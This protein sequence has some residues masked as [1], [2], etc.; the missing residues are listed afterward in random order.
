MTDTRPIWLAGLLAAL[1]ATA[2]FSAARTIAV[3]DDH[4]TI[5]DALLG[6]EA[7]DFVLVSCGVY[8][9]RNLRVPSG[10]TLWSATLQ[11]DCVVIDAQGRGRVFIFE[12]CDSTTAVVGFTLRGGRTTHDGGLVVARDAA[13]RLSRCRF[14]AG[15]AQRGGA[16]ACRGE[17]SPRLEECVFTGNAARTLG[18]AVL[19]RSTA[20]GR[21]IGCRF[22][23]NMAIG[24]GALAVSAGT[25]LRLERTRLV[26]NE[27]GNVGGAVWVGGG[28][29]ELRDCVLAR[30]V[31][32]L[33]GSA[34]AIAGGRPRL[35]GCTITGNLAD[36]D[37]A[38]VTLVRGGL[39]GERTLLAYNTPAAVDGTPTVAVELAAC[40]IYGHPGGDW[41][42][43]AAGFAGR[44]ENFSAD[45]LFCRP[46][47]PDYAL[48]GGSPCLPGGRG[49]ATTVL[50]G[51]TGRG[52]D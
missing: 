30:N 51:A 15:E 6:A 44:R 28:E 29:L 21:M 47:T 18:G 41:A 40:N 42:G 50:V 46:V 39:V 1:L 45:P 2:P 16:F 24:G 33:G 3:P 26:A 8:R 31:G 27:A 4:A 20:P 23:S 13:V 32:G 25:D 5:G 38:A 9:E 12:D 35:V 37:G 22:S 10:V 52:C 17:R 43:P 48:R 11:P 19:W 14:E 36:A 7:G 49:G 34:M